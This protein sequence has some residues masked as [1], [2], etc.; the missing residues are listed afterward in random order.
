MFCLFR[1]E[2]LVHSNETVWHHIIEDSHLNIR[3]V[4]TGTNSHITVYFMLFLQEKRARS[5][6]GSLS[7]ATAYICLSDLFRFKAV[8]NISHSGMSLHKCTSAALSDLQ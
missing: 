8:K 3:L 5:V 2:T 7:Q 1:T 4:F 6:A